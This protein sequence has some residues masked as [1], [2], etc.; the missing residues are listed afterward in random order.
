MLLID[1]ILRSNLF[2][3]HYIVQ[4]RVA[5]L[6]A[7]YRISEGFWFN[8]VELIMTF[9]FQFEDK[10]HC[11]NLSRA[12]STPLLFPRLLCQVLELIGFPTEPRLDR[13]RDCEAILTV[14]R[15]QI[16]PRSYHLPPSKLAEDQ[17]I[18]DLPTEEQPPPTVHTEEPQVPASSIPA[19][20]TTALVPTALAPFVPQEP[21]APSTL[22]PTNVAGPSTMTPPPHHISISTRDFLAIMDAVRTFSA[23]ST[24]FAITHATLVER[25]TCTEAAMA[26]TSA[27]L[28]QNQSILM[29][30]QIHLGL[31]LI[32][33]SVPTQASSALPPAG[34]APTAQPAPAAPLDLLAAAVVAATPPTTPAA[35]QPTQDVDDLPPATH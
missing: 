16:M 31:P 32:S 12:E 34:P 26:Q 23:T 13:R 25:M 35:P 29:Q 2:S 27:I 3:L 15:W 17:P 28:A 18:V 4:R 14:D 7:L 1:H 19:P 6:E 11:R 8:P 22:A 9:L 21:S 24:S 33:P 20:A 10:V 30:I 5:I